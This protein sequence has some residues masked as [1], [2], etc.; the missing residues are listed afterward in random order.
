MRRIVLDIETD[1]LNAKTIWVIVAKDIDTNEIFV[2]KDRQTMAH[3]VREFMTKVSRCIMHNGFAFDVPIIDII[4][5]DRF[6]EVDRWIPTN[7]NY[8]RFDIKEPKSFRF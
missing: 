8:T 4:E 2:F 6:N 1:G 3:E 5:K 7:S